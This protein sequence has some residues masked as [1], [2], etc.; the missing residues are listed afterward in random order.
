VDCESEERGRAKCGSVMA[1]N[2]FLSFLI[3][4]WRCQLTKNSFKKY[5]C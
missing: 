3:G 2:S 5:S 4:W 1:C